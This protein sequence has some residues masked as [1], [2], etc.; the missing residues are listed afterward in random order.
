MVVYCISFYILI[1]IF[2]D[3]SLGEN[4][5]QPSR[6]WEWHKNCNRKIK[7]VFYVRFGP[8]KCAYALLYKNNHL[9]EKAVRRSIFLR[10]QMSGEQ[11]KRF[12]SSRDVNVNCNPPARTPP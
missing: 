12:N 7:K 8:N 9:S 6:S 10:H 11:M 2:I 4:L 3:C 1:G 5:K